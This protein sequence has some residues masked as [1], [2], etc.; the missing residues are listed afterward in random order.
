MRLVQVLQRALKDITTWYPD[1][2]DLNSSFLF[3]LP[4]PR[5]SPTTKIPWHLA[6]ET[7]VI[8]IAVS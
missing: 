1:E 7:P 2:G 3:H 5:I 6:T 8:I 4:P